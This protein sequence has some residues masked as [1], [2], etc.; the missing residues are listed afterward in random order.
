MNAVAMDI[1]KER[2][3]KHQCRLVLLELPMDAAFYIN[4][5]V[6]NDPRF[7][8]SYISNYIDNTMF[9]EPTKASSSGLSNIM[10]PTTTACRS[11]ASIPI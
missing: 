3:L 5:Y 10:P 4:R 8:Y 1:I 2:I 7:K 11:W 6:K 9:D